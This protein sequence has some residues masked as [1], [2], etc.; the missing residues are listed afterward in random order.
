V[1]RDAAGIDLTG[2]DL[3]TEVVRTERL[4]LRPHRDDDV[5]AIHRACQDPDVQRWI[6]ALPLPYTL[7]EARTWATEVAPRERAEGR[8]MPV[9]VEAQGEVVGAGGA[10]LLPGRLGPEIGYWIAPWARRQGYAAEAAAGLAAWAL[11]HGAARVHL[12]TDVA[13]RASQAVARRAG[14]REEGVVRSCLGY[15]DG[16]RADALLFGRLATD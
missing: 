9:V 3:T 8:G 5:E 4:V 6:S 12:Y 10:H 7:D 14:F 15:R 13:N 2:I 11:G 16:T 1:T